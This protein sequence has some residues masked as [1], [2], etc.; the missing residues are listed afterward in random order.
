MTIPSK[1]IYSTIGRVDESLHQ[2]LYVATICQR[3]EP[4]K[5]II[6]ENLNYA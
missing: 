6:T 4:C 3:R 2:N 1:A 5:P